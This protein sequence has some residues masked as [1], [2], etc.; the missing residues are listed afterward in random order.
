MVKKIKKN[1]PNPQEE[2]ELK[3]E[4]A[5]LENN[6]DVELNDSVESIN[7]I[8]TLEKKNNEIK[9]DFSKFFSAKGKS[10]N[11]LE[12]LDVTSKEPVDQNLNPDDDI[13]RELFFYNIAKEN[14]IKGMLQLKQFKEKINRPDDFFAEMLKSDEQMTNVKKQI[15]KEQQYIKKFEAKKQKLQNIKFSKTLKDMKN[16]ES[17]MNKRNMEEGIRKWKEHIKT[18]P[19]DYQKIDKFISNKKRKKF[20]MNDLKGKSVRHKTKEKRIADTNYYKKK[21][22]KKRPGKVKRMMNR[23]KKNSRKNK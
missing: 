17:G 1:T 12:T 16:K 2:D 13:K 3:E 7:D 19:N 21:M 6:Q 15:I 23:N 14:A 22:M 4:I 18:S 9:E 5:N 10:L 8:E 11:W 20:N